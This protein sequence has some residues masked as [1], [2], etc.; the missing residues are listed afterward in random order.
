MLAKHIHRL[1]KHR[2]KTGVTVYFCTLDCN[3]KIEAAFALGKETICNICGKPFVMSEG[4]LKLVKPH[5]MNCGRKELKDP[6]TGKKYYVNVSKNTSV[7]EKIADENVNSLK[8]RLSKTAVVSSNN[9]VN[10]VEVINIPVE[11]DL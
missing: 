9:N 3:Y 10:T 5:C 8:D 1:K 4:S 7:S 6:I 2:Y 11:D